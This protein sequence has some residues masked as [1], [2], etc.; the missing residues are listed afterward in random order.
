MTLHLSS[1]DDAQH[2]HGPFSQ[3][4]N[5]VLEAL[6]G[7]LSRLVAAARANDPCSIALVV[8]DHGFTPITRK[9]NLYPAFIHAGLMQPGIDAQTQGLTVTSWQAQPWMAGG[10]AAIMLHEGNEQ[11]AVQVRELLRNLAADPRNGIAQILE[12]DAIKMRGGFP[13]AAF[14][15]IMQSGFTL[16]NDALGDMLGEVG[17]THGSHGFSPEYPQMRAAFFV[18]GAGIAHNRDL[19]IVDMRQIAPT[20]AQLL[21]V[22]L[23]SAKSAPLSIRP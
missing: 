23:P 8:S 5:Q 17:G 13:D 1:L 19:G 21:Q 9:L 3:Q 7:M 6:D 2:A 4:A 20:V 15:V 16:G 11:V 18:A 12:R 22:M 14:L 10:M